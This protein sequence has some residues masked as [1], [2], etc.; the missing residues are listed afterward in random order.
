LLNFASLSDDEKYISRCLQLAK[1]GEGAVAPNPMVGAV[2]VCNNSIIGE[3]YHQQFGGP[4]AEVNCIHSVA[5]E[6][7]PLIKESTLYVSLEPCSHFGKTPPCA[8]LIIRYGIK[9]V[10]IAVTD[11][12]E[13][14]S[15]SGIKKLEEAGVETILGVLEA[16]ARELNK[17]F[18][19]FHK[20]QAPFI[21]LKWAETADGYIAGPD[22]QQLAISNAISN[23]WVHRL[24]ATHAAIMVGYHTALHDDPALTTR[25]WP[26]QNA[27]RIVID[28]QLQ[29]P[30]TLRLLNDGLPT[31]VLNRCEQK[32]IGNLEYHLLNAEES[33]M[34]QVMRLLYQKNILSLLVE[35]GAILL[36]SCLDE[37]CWQEAFQ[38]KN[39]QLHIGEGTRAPK[40]VAV[41][42]QEFKLLSDE[43]SFFKND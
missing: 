11:P 28:K 39:T 33:V 16:E 6:H 20:K 7:I 19:H 22:F 26:G 15:G 9:K 3:G 14:V 29:L 8:D 17:Y 43:I 21:T 2:L 24:R 25:Y 5:D 35:G 30:Q 37:G 36:Q 42:Q 31:L 18:F 1:L 27:L 38:I 41:A 40:M 12:F 34:T 32:K 10:V 23:R 13:K 4:H